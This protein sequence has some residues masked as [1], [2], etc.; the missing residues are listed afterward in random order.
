MVDEGA[1]LGLGALG[2]TAAA[3]TG[4]GDRVHGAPEHPVQTDLRVVD[5]EQHVPDDGD[6]QPADLDE[7]AD[8]PESPQ[9]R[10]VVAGLVR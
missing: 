5:G 8:Q 10:L 6:R 4:P 9:V 1:Y 2:E 3:V 7:G